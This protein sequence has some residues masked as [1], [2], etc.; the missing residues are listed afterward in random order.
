MDVG[1]YTDSLPNFTL[2]RALDI[3]A[4]AGV[5][6][7]EIA[8][9]GQSAAPHLRVDELLGSAA[10]RASFRDAF[11][12]RGLRIA[13]LN[14]SAWPLHPVDGAFHD[15]IITKTMRLAGELGVDKVV[16]MSGCAGDGPGASTVNW[17]WFPWPDDAVAFGRRAWDLAVAY[18][19]AK[20]RLAEEAGVRRIAFE[21]HPLHVVYNAPTLLDFRRD[22]GS[23]LIGMN[24][25]PS[26]LF[27][28]QMDPVRVVRAVPDAV[29]HVH[30]KDTQ[31]NEA[32]VALA[33]VLDN[34][35]WTDPDHRAWVFATAG[36]AHDAAWWGG[37]IDALAEVGYDDCLSIEQEDPYVG[38]EEGVREAAAFTAALLAARAGSSPS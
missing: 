37:F 11:S 4:D 17:V 12:S 21:L 26:H 20:V 9:G 23:P 22:V 38:E 8:V 3:A 5:T 34:R 29:Y 2:E 35:P 33:G 13:A 36:R 6:A 25:D 27:W 28:Q 18:G 32:E 7:I 31:V 14:C 24:I 1:L 19:Q 15:A 16:S 10:K 30:I